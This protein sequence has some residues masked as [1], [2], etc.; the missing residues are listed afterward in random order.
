MEENFYRGRLEGKYG[1]EVLIPPPDDRAVIHAV[2]YEELVRGVIN[3]ASKAEFGRII[4]DLAG[5]GAEGMILGCTEIGLL[6]KDDD[7]RVALF[8]TTR[9]HAVASVEMALA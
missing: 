8:D 7:S 5:Q 2:I 9:L 1:L 4:A 3:P 6:V